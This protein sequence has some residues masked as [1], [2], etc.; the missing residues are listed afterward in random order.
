MAKRVNGE[1]APEDALSGLGVHL[2]DDKKDDH[3]KSNEIKGYTFYATDRVTVAQYLKALGQT[4]TEMPPHASVLLMTTS[5][6]AVAK[7]GYV[8]LSFNDQPL[9]ITGCA[10]QTK[11]TV[12]E[13]VDFVNSQF[14]ISSA[15]NA[16]D[17]AEPS[18]VSQ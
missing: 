1:D 9:S 11:C 4:V 7:T 15:L 17:N 13:F 3:F 12:P 8:E 10:T 16:C 2:L 6:D 5:T 14:T 18:F